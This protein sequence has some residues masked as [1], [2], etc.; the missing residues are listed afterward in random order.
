M[1]FTLSHAAAAL[2]FRRLK[3]VWPALVMGTFA[4]DLQYFIWISDEDRSGHHFPEVLFFTVPLALLLLWVFEWCVKD[5]MIE[6]LPS[7]VQRRLRDKLQPLSFWGWRRLAS[8]VLW[9]T[10]GITTHVFWDSFTHS[11]DWM[12]EH[13]RALGLKVAIPFHYPVPLY[14]LLQYGSTVLGLLAL[15]AWFVA[16]YRRATPVSNESLRELSPFR[17]VTIVFTMAAVAVLTGYPLAI[18]RL[19]DHERPINPLFFKVTVFEAITLVFC[20]QVLI[21]SLARTFGSRSRRTPAIRMDE[22]RS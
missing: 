11:H 21:Y 17:K 20:A 5:P 10:I 15:A 6:L 19:A 14:K 16:W 9:L 13:W 2:P 18:F 12:V 7:A 1:P 8:I 3:P 4:P 22:Q